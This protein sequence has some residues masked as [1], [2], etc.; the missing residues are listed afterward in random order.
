MAVNWISVDWGTT[1]FRAHLIGE[2]GAVIDRIYAEKGFIS[3]AAEGFE[4]VLVDLLMPWFEKHSQVPVLMAGM[5]GSKNG[6][7]EVPYV[8][9]PLNIQTLSTGCTLF[10]LSRGNKVLIIPGVCHNDIHDRQDVMRGEEVQAFGLAAKLNL[11]EFDAIFPGT[12]SKHVQW[13]TNE[14]TSVRTYMTGELYALLSEYS[15]LGRNLVTQ[16]QDI[17]FKVFSSGVMAGHSM[18]LSHALFMART[19]ALFHKVP[20]SLV[21]SYLS[22]I[23][24]GNELAD[25]TFTS[26]VYIVGDNK[27]SELYVKALNILEHNA[28]SVDSD[29]CFLAGM[30][31]VFQIYHKDLL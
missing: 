9:T 1:N 22:G 11:N 2:N 12:H 6:W 27:L 7:K 17:D 14:L 24:I 31:K 10:S 20:E 21:L 13:Q 15:I 30:E 29:Q 18:S 19:Q 26:T 3:I 25:L 4:Q 8:N 16:T 5:V 28:I 23:L